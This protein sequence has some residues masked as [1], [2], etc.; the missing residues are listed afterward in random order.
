M[1][2]DE[3]LTD[4]R[5]AFHFADQ[6]AGA[7]IPA[8]H[9]H[10]KCVL[11]RHGRK[12]PEAVRFDRLIHVLSSLPSV[13]LGETGK[14]PDEEGDRHKDIVKLHKSL[15]LACLWPNSHTVIGFCQNGRVDKTEQF[16]YS[17][18]VLKKILFYHG[19][20]KKLSRRPCL[21]LK[22]KYRAENNFFEEEQWHTAVAAME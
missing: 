20:T 18:Q 12:V 5:I 15:P 21:N 14:Q 9:Y 16:C 3:H 19:V 22:S 10:L 7:V 8:I 1:H 11:V 4:R 6:G 2:L 13:A 17:V